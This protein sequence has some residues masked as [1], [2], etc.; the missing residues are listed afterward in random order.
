[1]GMRI[2]ESILRAQQ[3]FYNVGSLSSLLSGSTL[4]ERREH[5]QYL[6]SGRGKP[7]CHGRPSHD[8]NIVF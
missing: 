1:M 6:L 4:Q 8:L 7:S 2:E 5:G 3:V